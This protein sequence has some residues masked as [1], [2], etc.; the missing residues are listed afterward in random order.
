MKFDYLITKDINEDKL[1]LKYKDKEFQFNV[2]ESINLI[3]SKKITPLPRH[4]LVVNIQ[5]NINSELFNL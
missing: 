2:G 3:V 4:K 1:T 5:D